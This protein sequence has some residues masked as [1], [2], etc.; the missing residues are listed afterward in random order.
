[1]G[2]SFYAQP[3][4]GY[5][6]LAWGSRGRVVLFLLRQRSEG[7]PMG[8]GGLGR[9]GHGVWMGLRVQEAEA[10]DDL[11]SRS[12]R[13]RSSRRRPGISP[14]ATNAQLVSLGEQGLAVAHQ[15]GPSLASSRSSIFSLRSFRRPRGDPA[16]AQGLEL[17]PLET[18]VFVRV[19]AALQGAAACH[20]QVT[21]Q[22]LSS[23]PS[24][25]RLCR[26]LCPGH[27]LMDG[28]PSCLHL[29]KSLPLRRLD[30][31]PSGAEPAPS[32]AP[33]AAR[34]GRELLPLWLRDCLAGCGQAV[35]HLAPPAPR[36]V[37]S[38]AGS[39]IPFAPQPLHGNPSVFS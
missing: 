15:P 28:S 1:M 36:R 5:A 22:I 12:L 34:P 16:S 21:P 26:L 10:G 7:S 2:R 25:H 9:G 14:S 23:P 24:S 19:V 27:S 18:T 38:P 32:L 4:S 8:F 33:T 30:V 3:F 20:P 37:S 29:C 39:Q 31:R 13:M 35:E 11:Q 6:S 17:E